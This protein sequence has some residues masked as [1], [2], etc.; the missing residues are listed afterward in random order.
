MKRSHKLLTLLMAMIMTL[1][2][3]T[4]CY[5]GVCVS[6][7]TITD[8]GGAGT[9][10]SYLYSPVVNRSYFTSCDAFVDFLNQYLAR[11]LETDAGIFTIRYEG[12]TDAEDAALVDPLYEMTEEERAKGYD[13]FSLQY[14]FS[15][16]R[17][18]NRKTRLLYN[19]SKDL[20]MQ[21]NDD[22]YRIGTL[23]DYVDTILRVTEI[24][25][26]YGEPTG[27]YDVILTETGSVSYGVVAWAMIVL[28]QQRTNTSLWNTDEIYY[29]PFSPDETHTIFSAVKTQLTVTVGETVR[30]VTP[31]TGPVIEGQG[32]VEG[33]VFNVS[34]TLKGAAPQGIHHVWYYAVGGVVS[35]LIAVFLLLFLW[36]RKKASKK[37]VSE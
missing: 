17:D 5:G 24:T 3:L 13:V 21:N 37:S 33:I 25:D 14:S 9:R 6:E 15:S 35:L 22:T 26:I 12:V 29:A 31:V 4:G 8:A 18:Y 36:K 30:T 23:D 10:I 20:V 11:A 34:G 1:F 27:F 7:L 19:L 16:I 28:Y 2:C 32:K